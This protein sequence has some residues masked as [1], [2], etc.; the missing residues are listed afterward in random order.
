MYTILVAD[1]SMSLLEFFTEYL[2]ESSFHL[3]IAWD[4]ESLFRE[5]KT[6]VPDLI[7]MDVKLNDSDGRK[8]CKLLKSTT[9]FQN[10][11]VILMSG[12]HRTLKNYGDF[13]AYD[14]LE[15]PFDIHQFSSKI[16]RA[17]QMDQ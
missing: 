15:K 2:K 8:L 13:D 6:G 3:K 7:L 12:S 14:I 9:G 10:T 5:L 1:D 4:E 17:L 11:P 16:R